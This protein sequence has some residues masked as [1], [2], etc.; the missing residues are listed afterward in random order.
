MI[1]EIKIDGM[2]V[3]IQEY[4]IRASAYYNEQTNHTHAFIRKYDKWYELWLSA[5]ISREG[6]KYLENYAQVDLTREQLIE[7]RDLIDK[8]LME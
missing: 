7:L 6:T 2:R 1:N 4:G 5:D 3:C 8:K